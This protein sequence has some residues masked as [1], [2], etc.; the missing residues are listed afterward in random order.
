MLGPG[1]SYA[2]LMRGA[3]DLKDAGQMSRLSLR[4]TKQQALKAAARLSLAEPLVIH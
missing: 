1:H 3:W 4:L 2:G